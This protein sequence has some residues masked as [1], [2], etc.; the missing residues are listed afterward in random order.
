M[1]SSPSRR[2]RR[3][4]FLV[5]ICIVTCWY[6][7]S[8]ATDLNGGSTHNDRPGLVVKPQ[9]PTENFEWNGTFR[10]PGQQEPV[11][12]DLTIRGMWQAGWLGKHFNLYMEQGYKGAR[13]W[14]ENLI[15]EKHFYT[16]T[17]N[18]PGFGPPVLG[19]CYKSLNEVTV[20]D[21]NTILMSAQLVGLE[22]INKIPMNHFRAS[23]LSKSQIVIGPVLLRAVRVNIFSDIYVQPGLSQPFERWLQ[24]GD[25]VGLSKQNDEW[26]FFEKHNQRP[27]EI[28]LPRECREFPVLVFQHACSNLAHRSD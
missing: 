18:W 28:R 15:Y 21:L 26:F 10:V 6:G 4:L 2:K 7:D 3:F 17:H 22:K 5:L 16:I 27:K 14:V 12:T 1:F 19:F 8:N 23:C 11:I 13:Y 20:K 25:A 9:I 24:F